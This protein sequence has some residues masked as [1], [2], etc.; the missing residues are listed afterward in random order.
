[1]VTIEE[2][3]TFA[4]EA[5]ELTTEEIAKGCGVSVQYVLDIAGDLGD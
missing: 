3:V 2:A 4:I 1:M 5:G